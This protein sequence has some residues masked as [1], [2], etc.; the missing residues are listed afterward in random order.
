[1]SLFDGISCGM[2]ALERAGI[3]VDRYVACEIEETAIEV[4]KSNYEQIEHL[5]DVREVDFKEYE[6]FD[7]LIGGSPCQDL[8]G[9]G[10]RKGLEG[11]KSSLFFE[12]ARALEEIKP[13]WFLLE[14]NASMTQENK[15]RISEILGCRPVL[16]NSADFSAQNRKRLYWTNIAIQD[17]TP[18]NIKLKDIMEQ[19]AERN[20]VTEKIEK[21]VFSGEY[22]GRK[23]EKTT[24][25]AI[26]TPEQ[27]SRTV[28]T[29]AYD[30]S[31][32]TGIVIEIENR[33]Y[34]PTQTEFERLQTLPDGYTKILPIKKAVFHIGNGWTVDVIAHIFRSLKFALDN[35]LQP[36]ELKERLR[37]IQLQKTQDCENR[38]SSE[39]ENE[40]VKN[41]Q[42]QGG[43]QMELKEKYESEIKALKA[44]IR[45]KDK[46]IE[47]QK[48]EIKE[49]KNKMFDVLY[50]K[51]CS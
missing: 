30:I 19:G 22:A 26:R 13:Q 32:N 27:Q 36:L 47:K 48:A 20:E 38:A 3:K 37:P 50:E 28:G 15:D 24:R 39:N 33:Y 29:G 18:K 25:N 9:M 31:S 1:M 41:E 34:Q 4:S 5:G 51:M 11:E 8:C 21:Y 12:F 40:K 42:K 7:L 49:I 14:N 23:I 44:T 45:E 17:F 2:I 43:K 35:S 46:E 6:G 10:S 16:I